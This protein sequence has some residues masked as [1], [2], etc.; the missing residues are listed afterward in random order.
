M[1]CSAAIRTRFTAAGSAPFELAA[2]VSLDTGE[3][4]VVLGPSASGKTL[5]LESIAG[6]HAHAG[7]V[8]VDGVPL[9]D[10]PPD[11]RG[12]GYVFQDY[13]LF[14]HLSVEANVRFGTRYRHSEVDVDALLDRLGVAH[15]RRRYPPTLSG[16]EQQRVALA[17][18]LA[19]RPRL[20]LLD[21]PLASL[22]RPA[23]E[24]L[25]H[26]LRALL[27][28]VSAILVT[29]DR[30]EA[31]MLGDRVAVMRAGRIVQSGPTEA[32]FDAPADDFVATFLG[33]VRLPAAHGAEGDRRVSCLPPESIG[34]V[35]AGEGRA[36]ARVEHVMREGA[37]YRVS[38]VLDGAGI[39]A[40][41]TRAP[42]P[43]TEVGLDWAD[44]DV[45]SVPRAH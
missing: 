10:R 36:R 40:L 15:L 3:T 27:E 31:R 21:E 4:L 18:A 12:L 11:A 42:A 35:G 13:A 16:G 20:L 41:V 26:D 44:R 43:G 37:Q 28:G 25:R 17:R 5:L 2:E 24:A 22:D 45:R 38:L 34:L 1:S 8:R 29:H 19:V 30:D 14:P 7:Q 39:D 33:Y 6:F 9:A 23:K 32:V